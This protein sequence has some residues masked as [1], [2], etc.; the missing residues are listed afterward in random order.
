MPIPKFPPSFQI[1]RR[2]FLDQSP[3]TEMTDHVT[4]TAGK[5]QLLYAK[6]KVFLHL[7]K[8]KTGNVEGFLTITKRTASTS[9]KE[10]AIN[11]IPKS[12]LNSEDVKTLEW[13]DLY[14]LDGEKEYS[15]YHEDANQTKQSSS[16]EPVKKAYITRPSNSSST[17]Y[18]FGVTIGSLYSIAVRPPSI[19]WK[20]SIILHSTL[21][22]RLPPIFFH[23]D[24][25][26]GF[27][28]ELSR[29]RKQ[30]Q[31]F[32]ENNLKGGEIPYWGGDRFITVLR[33][34]AAVEANPAEKTILM[35]NP[36]PSDLSTF[37]PQDAIERSND[38]TSLFGQGKWK[39]LTTMAKL[40]N[41]TKNKVNEVAQNFEQPEVKAISEDFESARVYLAKWALS[42]EEEANRTRSKLIL[43]DDYKS[44]L[45]EKLGKDFSSLVTPQ[46]INN[47]SRKDPLKKAEWD[48]Y[49]D[50]NGL[51][52]I[53]IQEIKD[54]IFHGGVDPEI[55]P[56]VWPY[57]LQVYPWDVSTQ[58]KHSL[59]IT[60]Q[61]QYLDLKTCWQTD[62]NKRETDLFKDQ[63][64]RIEKDINRTDRD[65]SIFKRLPEET[66]D[67]NEDVSVI[68]NPNLNTLRTILITYNELNANLGYV[69]GMN[70][71]LS[72]LYYVIRD[73]TIVFW[74]FVKFMDRMERNFVRDQSGMRLQMKTLNEL[75][76]F[77]LPE[78]YL[79][80]EKCES[81]NL[82]FFFRMLLVWFKREFPYETI[83]KL[84]E[85]FWTDYYSSQFH[86]FFALALLD[87]HSNTIINNLSRFDEVLKY[88]NDLSMTENDVDDLLMR[89]EL[90]FLKFRSMVNVIDIKE[91]Y[92]GSAQL[93]SSDLRDLIGT[94]L[95]IQKE[96]EP[97]SVE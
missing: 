91:R 42:I 27:K 29:K 46:D 40:T 69:Q 11:F 75:T 57:L 36:T 71:L 2:R 55:R 85:I 20:G 14:G 90:L 89:A 3:C 58:E 12:I 94:E 37:I 10:L 28:R 25:C 41:F 70:D 54:R 9:N 7:T 1:S 59:E 76:Q 66:S 24:E 47:A 45:I 79:H 73:E 33:K 83:L 93:I 44:L 72:P 48:S 74:S 32:S 97:C 67:D 56:Q 92:E 78:F 34:Y 81:N 62:I 80:L 43:N 15:P 53:T 39:L 23:D 13:F 19:H 4:S 87:K 77:M 60:L 86:L 63:K 18:A 52:K 51:P 38:K 84:W 82:F 30:F 17:A 50:T 6:S 16:N 21:G 31:P 8:H 96:N 5:S 64:F 22:E 49:F 95:V 68:K 61:E 35:I 65:I 88:F 26:P